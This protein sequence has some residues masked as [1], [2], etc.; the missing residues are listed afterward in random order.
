[1]F[2]L[3]DKVFKASYERREKWVVCPDCLGS[4]HLKV[5]L[6]D[7]SEVTIECGGCDPGGFEASTGRIRQYDYVTEIKEYTVTGVNLRAEEVGY[8]LNNFGH[9]SYYTG[10]NKDVLG[11]KEEALA[12][13]ERQRL[14]HEAAENKRWMAKTKDHKSWA[15]NASYHRRCAKKAEQELEY[16]RGKAQVCAAKAKASA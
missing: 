9:G 4:K 12:E 2:K 13:G 1:M 10:T 8:E 7:G 16:H 3:G 11:T 14:E 15:W 6:G 5:T